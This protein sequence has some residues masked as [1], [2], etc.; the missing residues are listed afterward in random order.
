MDKDEIVV[1]LDSYIKAMEQKK[2]NDEEIK[3]LESKIRTSVDSSYNY[4]FIRFFWPFLVLYPVLGTMIYMLFVF[5]IKPETYS[6]LYVCLIFGFAVY[7]IISAVIA[8]ALRKKKCEKEYRERVEVKLQN[9]EV[10]KKRI[11]ELK[12]DNTEK[13]MTIQE[14]KDLLPA[15]CRNLDSAKKIK[16]LL[17]KGKFDTIEEAVDFIS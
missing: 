15:S 2:A 7:F 16:M 4:T 17:I 10:R 13:L 1:S 6:G 9:D 8:K 3:D 14:H 11:E 5:L 12:R